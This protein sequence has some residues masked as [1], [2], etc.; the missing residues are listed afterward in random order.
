MLLQGGEGMKKLFIFFILIVTLTAPTYC[1]SIYAANKSSNDIL[2]ESPFAKQE[3]DATKMPSK[4]FTVKYVY[5]FTT[6]IKANISNRNFA[7][8]GFE[9]SSSGD[10]TLLGGMGIAMEIETYKD[11]LFGLSIN[12]DRKVT[13]AEVI[14]ESSLGGFTSSGDYDN[15]N[16]NLSS[17]YVKG[18]YSFT[19]Q[20]EKNFN[21]YIAGKLAYNL[22]GK[23]GSDFATLTIDSGFG[24][25]ASIGLIV[26]DSWDIELG[27]DSISGGIKEKVDLGGGFADT[28]D[29]TYQASNYWTSLGYRF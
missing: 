1:Q 13:H 24:V 19:K 6:S 17:I 14:I 21:L 4:M 20:T 23:S 8:T 10:Y 25:G 16:I 3:S 5:Y 11:V 29:G 27:F 2:W 12:T 18:R 9:L 15:A 28:V 26:N 7:G 22:M